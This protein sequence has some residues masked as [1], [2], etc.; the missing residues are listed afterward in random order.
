MCIVIGRARLKPAFRHF[1]GTDPF[2]FDMPFNIRM[3]TESDQHSMLG[4]RETP[5]DNGDTEFQLLLSYWD[6]V[7]YLPHQH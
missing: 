3:I 7:L 6:V 4:Y 2:G 5:A 1:E